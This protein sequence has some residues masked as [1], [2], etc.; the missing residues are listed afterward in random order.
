MTTTSLIHVG[1]FAAQ[2]SAR[3][4]GVALRGFSVI[5][6]LIVIVIIGLLISLLLPAVQSSREAARMT[7]CDNN[8]RQLGLAVLHHESAIKHFPTNGWAYYWVGDPNRG[9]GIKQPGGWIFNILPYIEQ[10]QL[11]SLQ[12]GLSGDQKMDAATTMV[13]TPVAVVMCPSRRQAR[14]YPASKFSSFFDTHTDNGCAKRLR[15]QRRRRPCRCH[16]HWSLPQ[17]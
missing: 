7:Q 10:N 13:T 17:I 1:C 8:L 9:A 15:G 12:A 5:E 16:I 14:L 11:Y 2:Q 4:R 6:L 3:R